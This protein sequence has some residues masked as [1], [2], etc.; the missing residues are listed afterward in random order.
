MK[1]KILIIA[2]SII[3]MVFTSI[4]TSY[5]ATS[6]LFTANEVQ[7]N[8]DSSGVQSDNLQGAI[9]ELY[10]EA[11][12]YTEMRKLI[13]PIGSIYMSTVDDTVEKVQARFGGTWQ[14]FAQGKTLV[15]VSASETEFSTIEKTGGE[16]THTLTI[17]EMPKHRHTILRQ[18]WYSADLVHSSSTGFIYSWKS[19]AGTGG[20]TY[21]SY[22][23]PDADLSQ[24]TSDMETTGSGSAHNNLPPYKT[25]YMY[26]R[27]A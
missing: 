17:A 9:D 10:E 25:I 4:V 23:S 7:Y 19:G 26:K 5:A 8:N 6:Y 18:Q 16:K 22:R 1:K 15:G 20:S 21:K 13:Y 12:D 3:I 11:T 2:T 14:A 27:T 24:H